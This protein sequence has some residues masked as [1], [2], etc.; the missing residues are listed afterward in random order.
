MYYHMV[1]DLG[2]L[3][4]VVVLVV[5]G[6]GVVVEVLLLVVD[7]VLVGVVV[8]VLVIY[9][10]QVLVFLSEHTILVNLQRRLCYDLRHFDRGFFTFSP[11]VNIL[12]P[13][14][15]PWL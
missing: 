13:P 9:L 11:C 7:R 8:L 12:P 15:A 10:L 5:V 1:E 4:V 14:R 6:V 2:M 3:V